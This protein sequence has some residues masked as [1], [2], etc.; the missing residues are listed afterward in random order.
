M[1]FS[2][3]KFHF[4]VTGA[5]LKNPRLRDT[6]HSDVETQIIRWFK[7]AADHG[8]RKKEDEDDSRC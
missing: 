8:G 6:Q 4:V 5:I 2:V 7:N 1:Y 3:I